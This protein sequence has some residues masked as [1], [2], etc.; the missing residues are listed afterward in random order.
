M[1]TGVSMACFL[2]ENRGEGLDGGEE[3]GFVA[4]DDHGVLE[5]GAEFTVGGLEGPAVGLFDDVGGA[6]GEEGFQGEDGAFGEAAFFGAVVKVGDEAGF[7]V[8][9]T[10][11]AV[12][13]EVFDDGVAAFAGEVFDDAS[14][15]LD[16]ES[17]AGDA[18]CF[19]EGFA[20]GVDE[21]LGPGGD[22]WDGEG[23]AGVGEKAVEFGGDVDV[24][25]VA[26]LDDLGAGDAVGGL[27]VD[28]D[29]GCAGEIVDEDG[30]GAGAVE[31][32]KFAAD[33]VEFGG[34]HAGFN[35]ASHF[36]DGEAHDAADAFEGVEVFLG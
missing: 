13:A 3:N 23:G 7:L 24:D 31:F 4:G 35:L 27:V 6:G 17:G 2:L 29:A 28:A 21:V 22:G 18:E 25:E 1:F 12:S 33:V 19:L 20:G 36:L 16:G 11:D 8:E 14:D 15:H 32:E 30:G 34:G 10:A 5:L 26:A 9:F